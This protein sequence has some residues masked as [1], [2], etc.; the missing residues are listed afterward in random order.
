MNITPIKYNA[1][2]KRQLLT[3]N[4]P[5]MSDG[6]SCI[7]IKNV[8]A[9]TVTVHDVIE[10]KPS[11]SWIFDNQPYVQINE[12]INIVFTPEVGKT[13]K[14]LIVKTYFSAKS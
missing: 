7:I 6:F 3:E 9:S 8:G 10:L 4:K 2:T 14:V 5:V 1:E 11:E 13:D 12:N